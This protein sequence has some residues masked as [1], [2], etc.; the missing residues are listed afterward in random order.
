VT[1]PG[2]PPGPQR[3]VVDVSARTVLK[4][5]ALALVFSWLGVSLFLAIALSPAVR[6]FERRGL[7]HTWAVAVVFLA[8]LAVLSAVA[9]VMII[10][11]ATQTDDLAKAAP[12][13]IEQLQDNSTIRRL[14]ERYDVLSRAQEQVADAPARAFGV[15]GE[16]LNG[17]VAT[18]TVL[19]LTLFLMLE[20]PRLSSGVLAAMKPE[21]AERA[22]YLA[23]EIN[24]NVGGYVAG[25]L[26]ISVIAGVTIGVSLWL[27]DVPYALALAVL[28]AIFD[29]IPLIGA[30][31]GATITVAVAFAA[32]GVVPG[33]ILIAINIGY[34]QFENHVLQPLVYR[35]TVQL[36]PF[37][38]LVAVL[39]G[40]TLL[41]VIG[42]LV[43]IPVAGSIQVVVREVMS[44][45]V[46]M[47]PEEPE[48]P[49]A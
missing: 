29:L 12:Q 6:F 17:A 14:D 45:W 1:S 32:A 5:L 36:S 24:R 41:G 42:A 15:A 22:R 48:P 13:Y 16:V 37:V 20:L 11:I 4:V 30:T 8:L 38:I 26:I 34:Q 7:S 19:F 47:R 21:A 25:N 10:P 18:I 35:R 44:N 31:I 2:G 3:L 40:A 43:A 39:I 28:V 9:S 33:L 49:I 23:A 46:G 27:L